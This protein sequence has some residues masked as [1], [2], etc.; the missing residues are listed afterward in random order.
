MGNVVLQNRAAL[1]DREV[2]RGTKSTLE[3][4]ETSFAYAQCI[5]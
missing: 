5:L 3:A 1:L 4:Q 2:F